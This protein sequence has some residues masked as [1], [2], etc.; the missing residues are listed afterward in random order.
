VHINAPPEWL[1]AIRVK[2]V[3]KIQNGELSDIILALLAIDSCS[4]PCS[5]FLKCN[6]LETV[7]DY[8]EFLRII[9]R[10]RPDSMCEMLN[11]LVMHLNHFGMKPNHAKLIVGMVQAYE[12]AGPD[13]AEIARS[14]MWP[15]YIVSYLGLWYRDAANEREM[16]EIDFSVIFLLLADLIAGMTQQAVSTLYDLQEHILVS[17]A[18]AHAFQ[19]LMSTMQRL[20]SET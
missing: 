8:A 6:R 11:T 2:L 13:Q 5:V 19:G 16:F 20:L 7:G 1:S 4:R 9:I 18:H 14:L 12:S 17:P 10:L 15:H 3:A